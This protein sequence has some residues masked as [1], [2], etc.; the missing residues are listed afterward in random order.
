MRCDQMPIY[1][2]VMVRELATRLKIS[3][4]IGIGV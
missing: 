2:N 4:G 3:A 1:Y